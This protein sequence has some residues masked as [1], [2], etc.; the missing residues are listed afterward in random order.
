MVA[1]LLLAA[2]AGTGQ[3]SDSPAAPVKAEGGN[4]QDGFGAVVNNSKY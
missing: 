4:V 3:I 1:V 2:C